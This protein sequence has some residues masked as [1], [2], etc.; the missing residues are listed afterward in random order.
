[1]EHYFK[2]N[3]WEIGACVNCKLKAVNI[4]RDVFVHS[5]FIYLLKWCF[6]FVLSSTWQRCSISDGHKR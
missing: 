4:R 6:Y 3:I 2:K 5:N 1:M